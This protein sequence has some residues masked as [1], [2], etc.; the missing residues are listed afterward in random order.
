MNLTVYP[1]DQKLVIS[2]EQPRRTEGTVLG[3][4]KQQVLIKF[5]K[6]TKDVSILHVFDLER[7]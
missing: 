1:Q 3:L 4:I 5:K 6:K 7:V 2:H